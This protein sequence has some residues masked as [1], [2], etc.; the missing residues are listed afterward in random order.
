VSDYE[1]LQDVNVGTKPREAK[2]TEG[3]ALDHTTVSKAVEHGRPDA[4]GARGAVHL[5]RMAGNAAMGS[6][7]Q[8]EAEESPVRDVVGKGGGTALDEGV[9]REAEAKLGGS[10]GDVRIH[11]DAKA[12]E[13]ATSVQSKAFTSGTDVV[14]NAG[15][16]QPDTPEGKQMLLHELV[17]V[18]QQ[19]SGPVDGTVREDGNKVSDPSDRFER[20]AEAKSH[21]ALAGDSH[22]GH[23]HAAAAGAGAGVQR[24]AAEEVQTDHDSSLQ[25]MDE[26]EGEEAHEEEPAANQ[27]MHDESIQREAEEDEEIPG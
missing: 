4:L 26:S 25:R 17:H 12:A 27:A 16:Y 18:D 3:A 5:Q 10:Y 24:E 7:V 8:R 22:G 23:D 11:T 1:L 21:A 13:A 20:E 6:L 19:R 2:E 9:R 15:N 14:F